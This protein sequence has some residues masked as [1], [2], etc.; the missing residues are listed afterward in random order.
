MII[1]DVEIDPGS[2]RDPSGFVFKRNGILF[3]QINNFYKENYDFLIASNLY[4][5][6][7]DKELLVPHEEVDAI[8][9][10]ESLAYKIIKFPIPMNGASIS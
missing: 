1:N 6:L 9:A 4:S 8:A 2:F 7:V 3:R 10:I 5:S